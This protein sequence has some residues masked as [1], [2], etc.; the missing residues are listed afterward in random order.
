VPTPQILVVEDEENIAFV[1]VAALRLAGFDVSEARTGREGLRMTA[2]IGAE[3]DL[4]VLDV[5]LPDLEGFEV[6]RRL[7]AERID[8]PVVFLTA[9]DRTEDRIRGLSIGGDDYLVKPFSVEELLARIRVVL[10]RSGKSVESP[11]ATCADLVLDDE[12]HRVTRQDRVVNLS[13][14]EYKLLRFLMHNKGRVMSREQIL[15]H[16]WDYSFDGESTVVETFVSSLRKKVEAEGRQLIKTVRGVG[17]R[18][19]D[20]LAR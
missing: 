11:L 19:D 20:D 6:C 18:I 15:D 8:T 2:E 16:V 14:T 4:I 13:P 9:R 1:V 5:M 17:Y 7:R 10:R 3:P 12:S